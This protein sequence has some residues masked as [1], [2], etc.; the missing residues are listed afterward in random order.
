LLIFK[1]KMPSF[2]KQLDP[3]KN[4]PSPSERGES[5]WSSTPARP[6]IKKE[7]IQF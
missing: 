3:K 5:S 2:S 7:G 4:H 6:K 1:A